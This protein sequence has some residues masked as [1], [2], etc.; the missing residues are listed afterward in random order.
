MS[1]HVRVVEIDPSSTAATSGTMATSPCRYAGVYFRYNGTGTPTLHITNM[2]RDLLASTSSA[3]QFLQDLK[4]DNEDL[5]NGEIVVTVSGA[6][7]GSDCR[8]ELFFHRQ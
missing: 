4:L 6:S 5:V 7:A 3:D 1:I 2:G 8:A